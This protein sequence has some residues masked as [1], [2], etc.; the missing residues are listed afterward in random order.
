[1]YVNANKICDFNIHLKFYFT[2][3]KYVVKI[4]KVNN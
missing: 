2:A 4:L 1:M 3:T